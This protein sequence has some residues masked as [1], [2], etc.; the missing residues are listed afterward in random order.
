[1]LTSAR[2]VQANKAEVKLQLVSIPWPVLLE[3]YTDICRLFVKQKGI[4]DCGNR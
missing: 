1:M 2:L 4:S 3:P